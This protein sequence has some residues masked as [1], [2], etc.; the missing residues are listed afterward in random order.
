[1]FS[2]VKDV[3]LYQAVSTCRDCSHLSGGS[4]CGD[5]SR[6]SSL[7]LFTE[8]VLAHWAV[9]TYQGCSYSRGSSHFS[10]LFS[11]LMAVLTHQERPHISGLF[12]LDEVVL[13]FSMAVLARRGCSHLSRL[14]SFIKAVWRADSVLT[15]RGFSSSRGC[16]RLPRLFL[17]VEA[18]LVY[19]GCS[20][21][22][23]VWSVPRQCLVELQAFS[24]FT[25]CKYALKVLSS[26][27]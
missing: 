5:C 13:T 26:E 4:N 15:Y 1:M 9:L 14:F 2:P 10:R 3:H 22:P 17:V 20:Q 23:R 11:V 16:S 19:P 6:R 25:S 18:V 8:A 24:V 7:F 12:P 21:L 27:F